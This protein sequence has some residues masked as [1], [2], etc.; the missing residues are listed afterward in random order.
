MSANA[1][2]WQLFLGVS[3]YYSHHTGETSWVRGD[4]I[5]N[6]TTGSN[7]EI[8]R[9]RTNSD[10]IY[11]EHAKTK[12]M[13]WLKKD[14]VSHSNN[15]TAPTDSKGSDAPQLKKEAKHKKRAAA[16]IKDPIKHREFV[17]EGYM[18]KKGGKIQTTWARRWFKLDAQNRQL[19]YYTSSDSPQ[20]KGLIDLA[21]VSW[22]FFKT[23]LN[24]FFALRL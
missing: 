19:L 7:P 9:K 2:L 5:Q 10:R 17:K 16:G 6:D 12:K 13:G 11:F 22:K 23:I 24:V 21:G 4:L 8:V 3:F 20:L 18:L 15:S 14:V 1:Y